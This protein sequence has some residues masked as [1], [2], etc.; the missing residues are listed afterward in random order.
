MA[1]KDSTEALTAELVGESAL[2]LGRAGTRLQTA[3]D[4]LAAHDAAGRPADDARRVLVDAAGEQ[5]W[6]FVVLRGALG[7]HD[8]DTALD[9]YKVPREV[10]MRMGVRRKATDEPAPPAT[11]RSN[12]EHRGPPYR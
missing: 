2:S 1:A 8:D 4:E 9:A 5:A 11:A 3:L 10:R 6:N 7:W 12:G